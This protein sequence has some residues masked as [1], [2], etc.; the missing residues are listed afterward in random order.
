MNNLESPKAVDVLKMTVVD[1]L[2]TPNSFLLTSTVK[3][4]ELLRA[5]EKVRH[6]MGPTELS[7]EPLLS[8]RLGV[9]KKALGHAVRIP[10][11]GLWV[12]GV[13]SSWNYPHLI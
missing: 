1:L 12:W 7:T 13:R 6:E 3:Q 5:L 11:F 9:T 4:S 10:G 8:V 2:V